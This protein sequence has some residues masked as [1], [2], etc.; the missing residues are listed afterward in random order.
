MDNMVQLVAAIMGSSVLTTLIVQWFG[1]KKTQADASTTAM[2][3]T[4][5]WAESMRKDIESLKD[6]F[7]EL[8]IKYEKLLI[9][10]SD[11]RVKIVSL[12]HQV[13]AYE[14]AHKS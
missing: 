14:K 11:M 9:E 12:E 1:R 10:N 7:K 2:D 13:Q 4:I 8:Q 6:E 3:G 5:K